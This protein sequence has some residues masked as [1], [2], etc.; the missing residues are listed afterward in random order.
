[1][2]LSFNNKNNERISND[3]S[4]KDIKRVNNF[5]EETKDDK[6]FKYLYLLGD[7]GCILYYKSDT[8]NR[9]INTG[10]SFTT[11]MN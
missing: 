4:K 1:M 3:Y 2:K 8:S 6:P 9:P 10:I 5:R 7:T 11:F